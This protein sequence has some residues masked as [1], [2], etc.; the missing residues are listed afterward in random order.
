MKSIYLSGGMEFK[1]DLGEGWRRLISPTLEELG[2]TIYD[3]TA[4]NSAKIE[5]LSIEEFYALKENNLDRYK[6][7]TR[8][9]IIKAD[10]LDILKSDIVL[11]YYD[12][13]A[14]RGAGTL[15][16]AAT[17]YLLGIPILVVTEYEVKDLPG[18][19]LGEIHAHY[20]TF[21][22]ALNFLSDTEQVDSLLTKCKRYAR[23]DPVVGAIKNY[24][25]KLFSEVKK[26]VRTSS[27]GSSCTCS[28]ADIKA[29]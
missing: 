20:K 18:W 22:E 29:V 23:K 28:N 17:A 3:P 4:N 6:E 5:G 26:D 24:L 27:C 16:E 15:S 19:L 14:R 8:K 21:K 10:Y 25:D 12:E 1:G 13:S 9:N 11:L 7:I 2:Y